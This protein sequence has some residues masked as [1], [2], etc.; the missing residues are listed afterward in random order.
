MLG[1]NNDVPAWNPV[2]VR[3]YKK[4]YDQTKNEPVYLQIA[5]AKSNG[6]PKIQ[7]LVFQDFLLADPKVLLFSAATRNAELMAVVKGSQ[8]HEI[9]WQM[10]KTGE[11]FTISGRLYMVAAPTMSH[12]FGAP[13][14]RVTIGDS[15]IHPD[16]FWEQERL[17][18]WKRLSPIYRASFTWPAPGESKHSLPKDGSSVYRAS[19]VRLTGATGIDTG[20]KYTRLDAMDENT[21]A[22]TGLFGALSG[23]VNGNGRAATNGSQLSKEEELRCVHNGALDNFCLLVMKAVKVDHWTPNTVAP[24]VRMLYEAMKDGSWTQEE[25]NP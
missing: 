7:R 21:G 20:Y 19:T 4:N 13:P 1:G 24:P 10:P 16:E 9:F 12:R 5:S 11:S 3:S 2:L 25:L 18:Q 14:R 23:F 15:D 6:V 8:T 22:A 17:R